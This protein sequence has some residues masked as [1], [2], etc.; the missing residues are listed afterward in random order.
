MGS[1][2]DAVLGH[3]SDPG[4]MRLATN[5]SRNDSAQG[6]AASWVRS[7]MGATPSGA[8]QEPHRACV[9]GQASS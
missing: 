9:I 4:G 8:W 3:T 5:S 1:V 2:P 7:D 6:T